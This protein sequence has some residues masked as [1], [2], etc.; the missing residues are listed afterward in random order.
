MSTLPVNNNMIHISQETNK[1][2]KSNALNP[3]VLKE[4]LIRTISLPILKTPTPSTSIFGKALSF[5]KDAV[6]K[7]IPIAK[8][9]ALSSTPIYGTIR[10]FKRGEIGW[11]IF[12]IA[13]D[14][15]LLIPVVGFGA[16]LAGAAGRLAITSLKAGI[17][18]SR[19]LEIAGN[20]TRAFDAAGHSLT[21]IEASIKSSRLSVPVAEQIAHP[22]IKE[23][24]KNF[25]ISSARAL[26]P[27]FELIY[28]GGKYA[29]K[30]GKY[31]TRSLTTNPM[32][33]FKSS[34]KWSNLKVITPPNAPPIKEYCF[35]HFNKLPENKLFGDFLTDVTRGEYTVNGK[36]FAA[37][38]NHDREILQK[39]FIS[40][41]PKN[42]LKQAQLASSYAN[43]AIFGEP[44]AAIMEKAPH[45]HAQPVENTHISYTMNSLDNN[46]IKLSALYERKVSIP[47]EIDDTIQAA[48][49]DK[50]F[51]GYGIKIDAILSPDKAADLH[52][53][54]YLK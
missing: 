38:T 5:V 2:F 50:Y 20:S 4:D 31:M 36:K 18:S 16:K 6:L 29:Y 13:T 53:S 30:G 21:G 51:T 12:G 34:F 23:T 25:A 3:G 48:K 33:F 19:V 37:E 26:D 27:G 24:A 35:Q 49:G 9:V 10:S 32:K 43:Q 40:M 14:I 39:Q 54:Y 47:D 42:D 22:S 44:V 28:K 15:L 11:G 52:Y 45:L 7:A 17:M 46:K 8:E 41:F 1:I